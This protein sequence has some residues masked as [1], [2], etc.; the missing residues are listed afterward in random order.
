MRV[1]LTTYGTAGDVYPVIALA[2]ALDELGHEAVLATSAAFAD[3]VE[4]AGVTFLPLPPEDWTLKEFQQAS[5]ALNAI[6]NPLRQLEEIYN[7]FEPFFGAFL[8]RLEAILPEY[9][10]LLGT[11]LLPNVRHVADRA[12]V[13]FVSL[14][15]CHNVV[16]A[17][18]VTPP[19]LPRFGFLPRLLRRFWNRSAWK[20]SDRVLDR[21][22]NTAL[23]PA[24]D[25][26]GLPRQK[27]WILNPA[28]KVL[29]TLPAALFRPDSLM[30]P[31]RFAFTGYLRWQ[32]PRHDATAQSVADFAEG[33]QVPVITFGSM[34]FED[35]E[36]KLSRFLK[37]WP[38]DRKLILQSGWA[39]FKAPA[40]RPEIRLVG[41]VAHNDLFRHASVIVHHGGAGTTGAALWAGKPQIV[42]PHIADQP[43]WSRE[44]ERLG[45]GRRLKRSVWPEKLGGLIQASEADPS[46]RTAAETRA[47]QVQAANGP[48][49]AVRALETFLE[50]RAL[51]AKTQTVQST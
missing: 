25:A 43:F 5:R 48:Q 49:N 4:A 12:G 14:C 26:R 28:E 40:D 6:R 37:H 32:P 20:A 47:T 45:V 24:M 31:E 36:A 35:A 15:F 39:G 30:D 27:G 10:L 41:K 46:Y 1:L 51:T 3:E 29:V 16:P 11:Y 22:L 18:E 34:A 17:T 23:G 13:P 21:A 42:V 8:D 19:N 2:R 38:R 33:Q 50:T 9:D 44:V 7:Q